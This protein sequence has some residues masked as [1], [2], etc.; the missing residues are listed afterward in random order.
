M[1]RGLAL[2]GASAFAFLGAVGEVEAK[3]VYYEIDGQRYSY[4]TNNRQQ[5]REAR[6]RIAAARASAPGRAAT[7]ASPFLGVFGAQPPRTAPETQ[8]SAPDTVTS[9]VVASDK[10]ARV[11]SSRAERRNKIREAKAERLRQRRQALAARR[12]A[13]A[14]QRRAALERRPPPADPEPQATETKAPEA[15]V[16]KPPVGEAKTAATAA[17]K[18]DG[19]SSDPWGLEA[20][21][22]KPA[23]LAAAPPPEPLVTQS[24]SAATVKTI[25]FDL[26]SG[27]KT[28]EM[29]DGTL[30]EEPFESGTVAALGLTSP[31]LD[32]SLRSF[33]DQLRTSRHDEATPG[34]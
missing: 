9:S 34:R 7:P 30:H 25:S 32:R 1:S 26:T 22:A 31:S 3:K 29:T 20:V 12:E 4:S 6:A 18:R 28:I 16:V 2:F 33:V 14:R 23:R 10:R 19:E 24:L 15:V 8:A 17:P 13:S 27:I 5:T 11:R 21:T